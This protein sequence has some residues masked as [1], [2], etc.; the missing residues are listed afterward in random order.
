MDS[1]SGTSEAKLGSNEYFYVE[2]LI[3]KFKYVLNTKNDITIYEIE[4]KP[5]S[6]QGPPLTFENSFEPDSNFTTNRYL[7]LVTDYVTR[8]NSKKDDL[9]QETRNESSRNVLPSLSAEPVD[10]KTTVTGV[11]TLKQ[12]AKKKKGSKSTKLQSS[13]LL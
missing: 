8:F 11:S 4:W 5:S 3:S 2:R 6:D 13:S 9:T 12:I 7:D 10:L 1:Y